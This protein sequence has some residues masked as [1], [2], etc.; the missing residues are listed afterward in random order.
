MQQMLSTSTESRVE[1]N[2]KFCD[3]ILCATRIG[4]Y[5]ELTLC[6]CKTCW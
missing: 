4:L 6:S 5:F 3:T 1:C 2:V